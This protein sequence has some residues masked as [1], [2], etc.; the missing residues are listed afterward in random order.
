MDSMALI[1]AAKHFFGMK[2]GQSLGDFMQEWKQLSPAD[3]KEIQAGLEQNG[4]V[5]K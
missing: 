5:I 1:A 3:Q 2:P 4:Y